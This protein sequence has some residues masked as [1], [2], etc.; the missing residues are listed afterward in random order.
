MSNKTPPITSFTPDSPEFEWLRSRASGWQFGEQGILAAI[1]ARLGDQGQC[2]EIG[3]GNG[4]G[5]PLT[6]HHF[7]ERGLPCVLFEANPASLASLRDIYPNA[8]IRG[9]FDRDAM[10]VIDPEPLLCVVDVDGEE[11]GIMRALLR[12][13]RPMV[14]MVEHMDTC[15]PHTTDDIGGIPS[16]LL[17]LR[18]DQTWVI[19][20]NA[21]TIYHEAKANGYARLGQTR[22]NSIFVRGEDVDKVERQ[23]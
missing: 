8:I 17:G 22:V 5:L 11:L 14:L 21:H 13:T 19:Q 12:R 2:V 23:G 15:C 3:A 16:W 6:I 10:S 4:H 18:V 20:H 1:T 7:Y 9:R